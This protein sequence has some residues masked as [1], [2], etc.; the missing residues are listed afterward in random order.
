MQCSSSLD[1][2]LAPITTTITV[3]DIGAG[4]AGISILGQTSSGV[5]NFGSCNGVDY[6][7]DIDASYV[8]ACTLDTDGDGIYNDLDTDSDGDGCPD[9]LEASGDFGYYDLDAN[10]ALSGG[11]DANGIPVVVSPSGQTITAA[12]TDNSIR[13]GC[14]NTVLTNRRITFRVNGN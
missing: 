13:S 8:I 10:S 1:P 4:V 2:L 12:V 14:P 6:Q 7:L 3:I 9:S 11:V 5:N